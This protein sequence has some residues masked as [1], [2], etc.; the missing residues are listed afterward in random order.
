MNFEEGKVKEVAS[1]SYYKEI[2]LTANTLKNLVLVL[3]C[4]K[5]LQDSDS[6]I[7]QKHQLV[8]I[9]QTGMCEYQTHYVKALRYFQLMNKDIEDKMFDFGNEVRTSDIGEG[10]ER[11]EVLSSEIAHLCDGVKVFM[12]ITTLYKNILIKMNELVQ[13]DGE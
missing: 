9:L 4:L 6:S 12:Q 13:N 8:D 3:E 2:E 1:T 7:F 11:F 10:I 5:N